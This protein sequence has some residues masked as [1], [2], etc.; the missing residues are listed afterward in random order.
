M[1]K[2]VLKAV[3]QVDKLENIHSDKF[4]QCYLMTFITF[5]R[6]TKAVM[7]LMLSFVILIIWGKYQKLL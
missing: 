2:R 3:K 5:T 6:V 1:K 4:C 7:Y